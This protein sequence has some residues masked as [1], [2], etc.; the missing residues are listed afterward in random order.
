MDTLKAS[1]NCIS[2]FA[3][4]VPLLSVITR[5]IRIEVNTLE[6]KLAAVIEPLERQITLLAET[7][8]KIYE[9][10]EF[11]NDQNLQ[12]MFRKNLTV[13]IDCVVKLHNIALL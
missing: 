4:G 1:A 3:D 12:R 2:D 13:Q 11:V 5:K 10:K 7:N 6:K 8:Q 9:R